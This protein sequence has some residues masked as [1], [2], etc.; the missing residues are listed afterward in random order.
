MHLYTEYIFKYVS[1][2]TLENVPAPDTIFKEDAMKNK[3]ST[4]SIVNVLYLSKSACI[5]V[6]FQ[7]GCQKQSS[8]SLI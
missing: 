5:E 2:R 8:T 6:F 1:F 3:A 4:S 7:R